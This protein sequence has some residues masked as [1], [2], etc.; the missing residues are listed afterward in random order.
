[1]SYDQATT[2]EIL[3]RYYFLLK[4]YTDLSLELAKKLEDFGR[5]R[6]ELQFIVVE[7]T[8]RNQKVE[9]PKELIDKVEQSVGDIKDGKKED[10]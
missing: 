5:I 8:K 4:K 3:D 9:D 6:Q 1:M 7:L 10:K 2:E